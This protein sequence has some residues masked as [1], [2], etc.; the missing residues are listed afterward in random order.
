MKSSPVPLISRLRSGLYIDIDKDAANT[1]FIT[2]TGRSGTTWLEDIINFD[3]SY[4]IIFEP[5]HYQ[6]QALLKSWHHRQYLRDQDNRFSEQIEIVLSGKVRS[7]W[8]DKFN[9]RLVCSKRLIKDIRTHF[10]MH[11]VHTH[12]PGIP[13]ILIL[14]HPCATALSKIKLNWRTNLSTYTDQ[15]ELLEDFFQ[16]FTAII[17]NTETRFEKYITQWCLENIVPLKQFNPGEILVC[18]YEDLCNHP[19]QELQRLFAFLNL[20]DVDRALRS[21]TKPSR[22]SHPHSA[23]KHTND[24]TGHWKTIITDKELAQADQILA[25]FGLDK[26]YGA[27]ASPK[28]SAEQILAMF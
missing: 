12:Y 23:I 6:Q 8:T 13:Q 22:M 2:G 5:F 27:D 11:W 16:P 9:R 1:V 15:P 14:R 26:V 20:Q 28:V 21:I 7:F 10:I 18:F 25:A 19:E 24:L 4:R 3:N 17:Q